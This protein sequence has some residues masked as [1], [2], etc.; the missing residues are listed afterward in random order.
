M[1]DNFPEQGEA[2]DLASRKVYPV[3]WGLIYRVVCAPKDMG[4]DEISDIVTRNDPPGTTVNQWVV[5]SDESAADHPNWSEQTGS[6]TA[7]AQC[8]DCTDRNHVLMNC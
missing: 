1:A 6:N 7:R 5:T 4:D 3:G 2:I 8:P